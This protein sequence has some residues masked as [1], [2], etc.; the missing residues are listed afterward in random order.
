LANVTIGIGAALIALGLAGYLVLP[1]VYGT[2]R[3]VTALIPAFVGAV[4]LILGGLAR[5]PNRRRTIMHIAV[6]VGFVGL[7][8]S[9]PGVPRVIE[10]LSGGEVARP[11]AA[12]AQSI[13]AVLLA[14]Y[15]GLCVKSFIDA[16]RSRNA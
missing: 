2:A 10:M 14:V 11:A 4:L 3:S 1:G 12:V 8:G 13:M 5:E 16:R 6:I 15:V 7:L 9:L